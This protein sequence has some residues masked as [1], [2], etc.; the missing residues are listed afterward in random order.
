MTF[1]SAIP[2]GISAAMEEENANND[3][4][5]GSIVTDIKNCFN[6]SISRSW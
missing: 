2:V 1:T 3:D 4:F 5:D 6:G